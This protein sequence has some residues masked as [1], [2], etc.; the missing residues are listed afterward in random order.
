MANEERELRKAG[1]KATLPRV[2]ILEALEE[3]AQSDQ[4]LSAEDIY[5]VLLEAGE[6]IG[7]ATVYRVMTQFEAAGLVERHRFEP[8]HS[9]FELATG[10]HHDHMFC[11]DT[12]EVTEFYDEEIERRQRDVVA[13]QGYELVSHTLVLYVKKKSHE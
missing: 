1:L 8:D 12:G 7:L 5:R 4:H 13:S 10:K 6:E 11:V 9:V 2:K 3:G